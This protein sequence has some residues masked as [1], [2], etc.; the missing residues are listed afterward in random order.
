[1][2]RSEQS[3]NAREEPFTLTVDQYG[4]LWLYTKQEGI[5][6]AIDLGEQ[7]V[8]YEIMAAAMVEADFERLPTQV[9]QAEA[10]NDDQISG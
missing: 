6:V 8:A 3:M 1:M 5:G 7:N 9:P 10:D 2:A 4:R